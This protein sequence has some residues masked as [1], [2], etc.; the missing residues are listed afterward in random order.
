MPAVILEASI[1]HAVLG[2]SASS[3]S[4]YHVHPA[5]R[6]SEHEPSFFSV[7][8]CDQLKM[9]MSFFFKKKN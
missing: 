1:Y 9:P 8:K 5:G 7:V 3:T 4:L 2:N 6:Q